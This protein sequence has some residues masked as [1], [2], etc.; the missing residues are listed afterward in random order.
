MK[1]GNS[2]PQ[3]MEDDNIFVVPFNRWQKGGQMFHRGH[4]T[5]AQQPEHTRL[6]NPSGLFMNHFN[7]LGIELWTN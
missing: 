5:A 1:E 6:P 2:L 7:G 4:V 3:Q